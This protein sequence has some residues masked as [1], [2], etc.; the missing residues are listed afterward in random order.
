TFPNARGLTLADGGPAANDERRSE[1]SLLLLVADGHIEAL[2]D[3]TDRRRLWRLAG[4][5]GL[6]LH[7]VAFLS[8]P[9]ND[10]ERQGL[11]DDEVVATVVDGVAFPDHDMASAVRIACQAQATHDAMAVETPMVELVLFDDVLLFLRQVCVGKEVAAEVAGALEAHQFAARHRRGR[12]GGWA[13]GGE[14]ARRRLRRQGAVGP[15]FP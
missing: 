3:L 2:P 6:G 12:G 15:H 5:G 10:V 1:L 13:G 4:I 11:T 9:S 8:Q 7:Q 14:R